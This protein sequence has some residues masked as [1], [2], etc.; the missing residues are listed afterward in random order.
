[1]EI[2]RPS[3]VRL[4]RQAGVK[5]I[6]EDCYPMIRALIDARLD[7]II[8]KSLRVNEQH[9][10]KTLM[11][12]DVYEALALCGEHIAQSSDLGTTTIAK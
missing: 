5:S 12:D 4:A 11:A 7:D 2:T 9:Q 10:T 3:I 8:E 1:M 6:A